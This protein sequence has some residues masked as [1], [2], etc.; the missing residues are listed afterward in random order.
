[1]YKEGVTQK[2][3]LMNGWVVI[4]LVVVGEPLS[5]SISLFVSPHGLQLSIW[6]ERSDHYLKEILNPA[7]HTS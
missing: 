2:P 3:D 1:M 4:T 6:M 5:I 7:F